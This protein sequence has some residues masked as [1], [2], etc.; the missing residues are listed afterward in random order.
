MQKLGKAG[1]TTFRIADPMSIVS[2]V[3]GIMI[4]TAV[5]SALVPTAITN[6]YTM[7]IGAT[8]LSTANRLTIANIIGSMQFIIYLLAAIG[9]VMTLIYSFMSKGK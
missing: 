2:I 9:C 6:L 8:N 4:L 5:I 3:V 7:V 1:K